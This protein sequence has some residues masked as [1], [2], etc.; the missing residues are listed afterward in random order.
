MC[1]SYG[2]LSFPGGFDNKESSHSV[3]DLGPILGQRRSPGEGN[4]YP[5]QYSRLENPKNRESWW[6]I[7]HGVAKSQTH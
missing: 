5:F 6:A 2:L 3:G 4:G 7:V 1:V